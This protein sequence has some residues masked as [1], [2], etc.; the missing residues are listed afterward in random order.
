MRQ[1]SPF[2]RNNNQN[3]KNNNNKCSGQRHNSK[4][5]NGY[6]RFDDRQRSNSCNNR[7]QTNS[8]DRDNRNSLSNREQNKRYPSRDRNKDRNNYDNRNKSRINNIHTKTQNDD[9]PGIDEY[10][11]TSE[12]S[13]EDQAIL[14]K[15]YNANEDTCNSII[16][17]LE[18]NPAWILPMYHCTKLEQNFT[19]QKPIREIDFLLDSGATLNL[20]NEDTWNEIKYNNPEINLEKANEILTAANNTTIETIG[21]VKLELTPERV[22]NGRSKTQQIFTIYFYVTQCNNNILGTQSFFKEYIETINV[23]IN[24]LTNTIRDNDITFFMS[25]TKGYP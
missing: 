20:L 23:N 6:R 19:K 8:Y 25:S 21:A 4:Q 14:D 24:K 12:S 11:Y 16:N 9:P 2:S 13:N 15:F 1:N 22:T 7:Y 3:N 17:T 5:S 10:E 18:S